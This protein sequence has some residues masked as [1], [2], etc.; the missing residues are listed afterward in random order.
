MKN[1]RNTG[2]NELFMIKTKVLRYCFCLYLNNQ[3]NL[4]KWCKPHKA[5]QFGVFKM[6]AVKFLFL[7]LLFVTQVSF[8]AQKSL[9]DFL[10]DLK[11]TPQDFHGKS[12][13]KQKAMLNKSYKKLA[14]EW[15]PDKLPSEVLAGTAEAT[16]TIAQLKEWCGKRDLKELFEID[17]AKTTFTKAELSNFYTNKEKIILD[18]GE[19][20]CKSDKD[21][22]TITTTISRA[23]GGYSQIKKEALIVFPLLG[24]WYLYDKYQSRKALQEKIKNNPRLLPKDKALYLKEIN[25]LSFW[26]TPGETA[27]AIGWLALLGLGYRF[28]QISTA[29]TQVGTFE[30]NENPQHPSSPAANEPLAPQQSHEDPD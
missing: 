17:R 8:A 19:Q 30:P 15:H 26:F 2:K 23:T 9:G 5:K 13:E 7:T 24:I 28:N 21:F 20:L 1:Q 18:A 3:I 6:N 10:R 22:S 29:I 4:F 27:K 16:Y 12:I 11:L 25:K 14:L